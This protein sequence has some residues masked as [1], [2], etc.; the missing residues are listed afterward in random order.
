MSV[1]HY[2]G[3][4][5][6]RRPT[7][8]DPWDAPDVCACPPASVGWRMGERLAPQD[9]EIMPDDAPRFERVVRGPVT[10]DLEGAW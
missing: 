4:C 10:P 9:Y 1:V 2:C 5:G 7:D 6:R 3:R 8:A